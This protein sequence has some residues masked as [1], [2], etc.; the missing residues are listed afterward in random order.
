[1]WWEF[2]IIIL[3]IQIAKNPEIF[4]IQFR[5]QKGL[6]TIV[7]ILC[8]MLTTAMTRNKTSELS[9]AYNWHLQIM[10]IYKYG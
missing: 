4:L 7:C 8:K 5:G 9:V 2:K 3:A 6:K 1:M 10:R